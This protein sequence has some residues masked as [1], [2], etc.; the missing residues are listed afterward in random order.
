MVVSRRFRQNIF[1]YTFR[2]FSRSL[3]SLQHYQNPQARFHICTTCT[4]HIADQPQPLYNILSCQTH[5]PRDRAPGVAWKSSCRC[6]DFENACLPSSIPFSSAQTLT[7]YLDQFSGVSCDQPNT[8]RGTMTRVKREWR[9]DSISLEC[10]SRL[11]QREK[12][13]TQ[14]SET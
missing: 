6:V 9:A 3:V 2:E 7:F 5:H 14:I 8:F 4:V 1:N 12:C 11:S 13:R 10:R